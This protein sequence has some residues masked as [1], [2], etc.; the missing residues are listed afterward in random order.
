[1]NKPL[2]FDEISEVDGKLCEYYELTDYGLENYHGEMKSGPNGPY[3][4]EGVWCS[5]A[6]ER[7][8]E[9]FEEEQ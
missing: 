6:Y 1:M 7:Y 3:G 4:C 5:E 2:S 8:L 9:D